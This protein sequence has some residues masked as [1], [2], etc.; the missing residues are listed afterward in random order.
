MAIPVP[1]A[2]PRIPGAYTSNVLNKLKA[3]NIGSESCE[4]ICHNCEFNLSYL[5]VWPTNMMLS[6]LINIA[7]QDTLPI[8]CPNVLYEQQRTFD[9]TCR[10][11]GVPLRK[12]VERRIK[13]EHTNSN[14]GSSK[15]WGIG[16][17]QLTVKLEIWLSK[18]TREGL[19]LD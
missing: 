17:I 16:L 6:K 19:K 8:R 5:Q 14:N 10:P 7:Y 15:R 2:H 18:A 1:G 12:N 13:L 11:L 3:V 9:C 4:L